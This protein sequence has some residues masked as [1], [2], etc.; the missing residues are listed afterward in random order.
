MSNAGSLRRSPH[1]LGIILALLLLGLAALPTAAA[2]RPSVTIQFLNVSD[3]HGQLDPL[4]VTGVGNV[5]GAA[6]LATYFANERA[7]TEEADVRQQRADG[8]RVEAAHI[9]WRR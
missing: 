1:I 8:I 9:D 7:A 2:P 4:S 3:W 6:A 5:G